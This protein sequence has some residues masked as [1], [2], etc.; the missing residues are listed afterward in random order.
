MINR[1]LWLKATEEVER[2]ELPPSDALT[3]AEYAALIGA[4]RFA[5][6]K[7]LDR[8]LAQGKV[9]IVTKVIRRTDGNL[10]R[11]RAFRLLKSEPRKR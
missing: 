9:E 5:A 1:D 2:A 11:V 10:L 4:Q 8:L 3:M 7:R 6:K